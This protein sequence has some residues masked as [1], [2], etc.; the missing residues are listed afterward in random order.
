[1]TSKEAKRRTKIANAM[2]KHRTLLDANREIEI[3]EN[4]ARGTDCSSVCPAALPNGSDVPVSK[5]S[6][7]KESASREASATTR[8]VIQTR[9]MTRRDLICSE[10]NGNQPLSPAEKK[11][12]WREKLEP[13]RIAT[14]RRVETEGRRARRNELDPDER[15]AI[16]AA[17]TEGRRVRWDEL[18]PDGRRAIRQIETRSKARRR[19]EL[20]GERANLLREADSTSR[21]QARRNPD[22]RASENQARSARQRA[23]KTSLEPDSALSAQDIFSG[24]LIVDP[25]S[26]TSDSIGGMTE[27]CPKC[28]AKKF[29]RE[30]GSLCC[31]SGKVSLEHFPYP[32]PALKDLWESD[33]RLGKTFRKHS[34]TIN[35]AVCLS[36]LV[37]KVKTFR[38][39]T[40][41]VIFQGQ[42]THLL[43]PLSN[44]EGERPQYAQIYVHDP[45]L[46]E[47]IRFNNLIIPRNMSLVEKQALQD[48]VRRVQECLVEVNPFIRDFRQI[49]ELGDEELAQG[50]III[51]PNQR[52][53]NQHPRRYNRASSFNEV[54]ILM[55]EQPHDLVVRP[56]S[57]GLTTISDLNSAG[58][59]LH[60]TLLFPYGTRGWHPELRHSASSQGRS[61]RV[62]PREFF[63]FH[64]NVREGSS[65]HIVRAGRLFQEWLCM[66]WTITEDQKLNYLRCNQQHLRVDKYRSVRGHQSEIAGD[67]LFQD[68][69]NLRIGRK[70][71]PSSFV[72]GPRYLNQQFQ[73]AMC[74]CRKFRK[75][76]L[77][78]THTFNPNCPELQS[79]LLDGQ[80]AHDRPD[81]VA[82][83]FNLL[84]KQLI[85]NIMSGEVFGKVKGLL[86]VI[87]FQKRGLP[88]CHILVCLS[89]KA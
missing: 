39:Y 37:V 84:N 40:P 87:E 72:G 14:N 66:A 80:Q 44:S 4:A 17:D 29:S 53:R 50:K 52:P 22:V 20:D 71:L 51:S 21:S 81:L 49:M 73:S 30:T 70:V 15:L 8:R 41:S 31:S 42:V 35:N 68:D 64:L 26:D 45:S 83:C 77:F 55:D 18:G 54:S 47:S 57:G 10:T 75:P 23:R 86:Y 11:R 48:V 27:I 28:Q 65:D 25:I 46:E 76:D 63:A 9:S 89:N 6:R 16:R 59:P 85:H 60:F 33:D 13:D 32:P 69:S 56:R 74:I 82:R 38:G 62:T 7:V 88:H 43:G 67:Q 19:L 2:A 58:M 79:Q 24:A 1:M 34:R 36:S 5:F 78:I 3:Q 12:R 61:R